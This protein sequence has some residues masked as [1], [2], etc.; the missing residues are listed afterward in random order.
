MR[1]ETTGAD[2]KAVSFTMHLTPSEVEVVGTAAKAAGGAPAAAGA[3]AGGGGS[4][5]AG[6]GGPFAKCIADGEVFEVRCAAARRAP[7]G[8]A[9]R[10][11]FVR[12]RSRQLR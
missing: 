6:A 7:R 9:P 12:R 4:G 8:S 3:K 11:A 5:A 10:G 2:G 1:L